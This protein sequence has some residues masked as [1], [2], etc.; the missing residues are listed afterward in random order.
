MSKRMLD[1]NA[2]RALVDGDS[3]RLDGLFAEQRCCISVIAAAEIHYGLEKK[4]LNA[5]QRQLI[6]A[7][8]ARL[9][10]LPWT[11]ACAVVYGRLRVEQSRKGRPLGLMDLLIASHALSEGCVLVTADQAF[12]LVEELS[13]EAW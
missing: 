6:E 5:R 11:E 8:L 12:A 7:G 10:V 13:L 1:T 4:E 9:E 2:V 3:P